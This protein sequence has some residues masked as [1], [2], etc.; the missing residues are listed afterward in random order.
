MSTVPLTKLQST[1]SSPQTSQ[2]SEVPD[3]F[4]STF[5]GLANTNGNAYTS[6]LGDFWT[7]IREFWRSENTPDARSTLAKNILSL[8]A[9]KWQ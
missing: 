5:D 6:D 1:A 4:Q 7:P 9:T 8:E 3:T 2:G